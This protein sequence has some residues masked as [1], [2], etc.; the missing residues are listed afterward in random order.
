MKSELDGKSCRLKSLLLS[1]LTRILKLKRGI[2]HVKLVFYNQSVTL[3]R[4]NAE[5]W[6]L[7]TTYGFI[8]VST[9]K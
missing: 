7:D 1:N 5:V 6:Y 4:E 3:E 2:K 9:W 8:E